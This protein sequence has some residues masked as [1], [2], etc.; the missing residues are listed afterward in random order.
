MFR[1]GLFLYF[2]IIICLNN[3]DRQKSQDWVYAEQ[4]QKHHQNPLPVSKTFPATLI[5]H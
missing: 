1:N 5:E 4:K 3:G 2:E